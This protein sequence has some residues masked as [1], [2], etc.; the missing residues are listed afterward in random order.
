[1]TTRR[2]ALRTSGAA[3]LRDIVRETRFGEVGSS[4]AVATS[5]CVGSR[6]IRPA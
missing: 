4:F 3:A 2:I 5:R 1:M 6:A